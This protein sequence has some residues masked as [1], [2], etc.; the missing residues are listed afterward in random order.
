M[1]PGAFKSEPKEAKRQ[2]KGAKREPTG[3]QNE[4]KDANIS[5]SCSKIEP[6]RLRKFRFPQNCT[7]CHGALVGITVEKITRV[8]NLLLLSTLSLARKAV[9]PPPRKSVL[10]GWC[11]YSR[12]VGV[13]A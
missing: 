8:E 1:T 7:S 4:S 3:R 13:G 11:V 10:L 5:K 12:R 9:V 2:P 6:S